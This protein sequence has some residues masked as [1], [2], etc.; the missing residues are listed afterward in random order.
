M[1]KNLYG[2]VILQK[3]SILY[4]ASEEIFAYKQQQLKDVIMKI[5]RKR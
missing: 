1:L 3:D 5:I 4:H 2:E